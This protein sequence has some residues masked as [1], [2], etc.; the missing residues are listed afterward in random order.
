MAPPQDPGPRGQLAGIR[1]WTSPLDLGIAVVL[2]GAGVVSVARIAEETHPWAELGAAVAL[3]SVAFRTKA[4][5]VMVVLCC[6]GLAAYALLPYP[7]T[8]LPLFVG[9][10]VVSFSAGA[11]IAGR[12]GL[13]AVVALMGV[14]LLIQLQT[15][16]TASADEQSWADVY[17][18]PLVIVGGPALAGGLLRRSR[19]QTA[20]LR[21]VTAELAAERLVHAEAAVAAERARI[22]RELH[23]VIS[24]SVSVMV[25]QAGAAEQA[26]PAGDAARAQVHAIRTTGKEALA[27][28]RRQLGVLHPDDPVGPAPLPGIDDIEALAAD[29][30]ATVLLEGTPRP[31]L[32]AGTSLTAFRVVQESLTNAR[33]HAFGGSVTVRVTFHNGGI[34]LVTEDTGGIQ[35]STGSGFGLRGIRERVEMYGGRVEAGPRTNEPGWRVHAWIPTLPVEAGP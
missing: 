28:L 33:R 30:G 26:L 5:M 18:T 9:T 24:H 3:V 32:P 27:E 6:T 29:G 23:D 16:A 12:P 4:P 10:L 11:G 31:D 19:H 35:T 34:D 7:G 1:R 8:P 25:I 20:E 21:R 15:Q 17:L 14:V 13:V 22:A 2:A